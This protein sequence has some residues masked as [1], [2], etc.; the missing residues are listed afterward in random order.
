MEVAALAVPAHL[1]PLQYTCPTFNTTKIPNSSSLL[2]NWDQFQLIIVAFLFSFSHRIIMP[3]HFPFPN[4][5]HCLPISL[6]Q[7]LISAAPAHVSH[8]QSK[9]ANSSSMPSHFQVIIIAVS[10]I[11]PDSSRQKTMPLMLAHC[12][13]GLP[14][15]MTVAVTHG[16]SLPMTVTVTR[17]LLLPTTG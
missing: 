10:T 17:G 16:L 2:S 4:H 12:T 1:P 5:H 6:I 9:I 7:L 3:S 11:A 13:H 15:P 14:L 8:T